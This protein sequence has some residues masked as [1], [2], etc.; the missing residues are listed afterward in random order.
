MFSC[1]SVCVHAVIIITDLNELSGIKR[2]TSLNPLRTCHLQAN[3]PS[4]TG[5]GRNELVMLGDK[6]TEQVLRVKL[7]GG[8]REAVK[9]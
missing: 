7:Q 4:N 2:N 1:S 5:V 6:N 9:Q 3:S 8:R